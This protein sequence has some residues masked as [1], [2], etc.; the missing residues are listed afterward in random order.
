[1]NA[2]TSNTAGQATYRVRG[3]TDDVTICER[4]GKPELKGT[5]I[6]DVLDTD[7]NTEEITYF[8]T[9]CAAR[10]TGRKATA[11][12]NDASGADYRRIEAVRN[13]EECIA[14]YAPFEV[15]GPVQLGFAYYT[16][17]KMFF[18]RHPGANATEMAQA[19]L[20]RHRETVATDGLS[21][22]RAAS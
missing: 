19:S 3:T 22:L 20:A 9:T 12:K 11:I 1:M 2:N 6:L 13:A 17:N 16:A 14:H 10:V 8:G 18:Q 4:C 15:E 5:V 21:S 7:G